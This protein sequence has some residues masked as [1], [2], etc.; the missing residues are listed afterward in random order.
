MANHPNNPPEPF[1]CTYSPNLP[2]LLL[3][4][5]CTIAIST[6]QAGKVVFISAVDENNL[7]Q[8]PRNFSKAMGLAINFIST[9]SLSVK[10]PGQDNV[11]IAK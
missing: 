9:V 11:K 4:L 8:L 2:E 10:P 5:K 1:S 6:Y 3:Q 7:V